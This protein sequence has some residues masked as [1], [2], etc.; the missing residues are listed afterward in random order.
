V[1][2]LIASRGLILEALEA[3]GIPAAT[4][5][6]FSAPCVLVEPGDPWA[7]VER[8]QGRGSRLGRWQLTAIAGRSDTDAAF[9]E[10]AD[11]VDRVDAAVLTVAGLQLPTWAR[12]TDRQL[13]GASYGATVATVQL[14][15]PKEEAAR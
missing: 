13:G 10:L 5:G 7:D 8:L 11:L 1:S 12:P 2:R 9:T 15:T 6:R 14:M 3:A 4:G